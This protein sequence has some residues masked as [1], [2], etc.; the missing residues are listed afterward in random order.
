[1]RATTTARIIGDE[2]V[3]MLDLLEMCSSFEELAIRPEYHR[4]LEKLDLVTASERP[5]PGDSGQSE[6]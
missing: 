2:L 6:S 4:V 5:E 1:M 3:S